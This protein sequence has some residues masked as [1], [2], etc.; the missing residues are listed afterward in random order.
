MRTSPTNVS[1]Q[2][3]AT[4]SAWDLGFITLDD[5]ADRLERTFA[6]LRRLRRYR[7]HFYNWYD[8]PPS[9]CWSRRTSR[10]WTA[11]TSPGTSWRCG[12]RCSRH[13][14][15]RWYDGRVRAR[16]GRGALARR[17]PGGQGRRRSASASAAARGARCRGAPAD[18]EALLAVGTALTWE[19][20]AARPAGRRN[21]STGAAG[22]PSS[23]RRDREPAFSAP[24]ARREQE[25]GAVSETWREL[26]ARVA[27]GGRRSWPGSR[28]SPQQCAAIVAEMD[29]GFLYDR[30]RSLFAIGYRSGSPTLDPSYYDLLASEARLASFMAVARGEVPVEHWFR[31][32]RDPHPRRGRDGA[33]VVEREHVRVPDAGAW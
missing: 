18:P 33:G 20:L 16:A 13:P 32:G 5:M 23:T 25:S 19:W 15:S 24:D 27:G 4:V 1:L 11:A 22:S 30:S 29:F 2:L 3:L 21:G 8:L 28:R 17:R 14:S 6:T 26:A 12:R 7:G 9:R 10:P 31:L